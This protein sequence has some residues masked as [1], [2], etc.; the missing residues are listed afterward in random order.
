MEGGGGVYP[1]WLSYRG[2]VQDPLG[3]LGGI[4]TPRRDIFKSW[5][6]FIHMTMYQKFLLLSS[7]TI[8]CFLHFCFFVKTA[9]VMY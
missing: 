4:Q 7:L 3:V 8:F 5:P 2:V 6:A 1:N 9:L